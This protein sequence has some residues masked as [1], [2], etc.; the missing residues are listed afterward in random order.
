MTL[1]RGKLAKH[2]RVL[3]VRPLT[4]EDLARL[5]ADAG[6]VVPRVRVYRETHHRL[7]RLC[8]AGLR[9][10]EICRITGYSPQRLITL[11][12]DP[13][14]A[15]LIVEYKSKLDDN[16][17]RNPD[18]RAEIA[19]ENLNRMEQMIS[20]HLDEADESGVKIPWKELIV[21]IADREDRFGHSKRSQLNAN[22][23]IG[24]AKGLERAMAVRG[25]SQ[26]IDAR[27]VPLPTI[28]S[29]ARG[30]APSN[31]PVPERTFRRRF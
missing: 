12:Q 26:V 9:S 16:W 30:P 5:H 7:A 10:E 27:V 3:S 22:H 6:R 21:A 13:A 19:I 28:A 18:H 24:F 23:T 4:R 20:D 8:A 17:A 14:F 25:Q 29:S 31:P 1:H 15:Q 2:P 11:R